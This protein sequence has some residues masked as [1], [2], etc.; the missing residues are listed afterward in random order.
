MM[1]KRVKKAMIMPVPFSQAKTGLALLVPTL[2]VLL[3]LAE[4]VV[5]R[6]GVPVILPCKS[7]ALGVGVGMGEGLPF[8]DGRTT[9]VIRLVL[10]VSAK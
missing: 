1:I 3:V 10:K 8:V 6:K 9:I 5:I 4:T 7:I 2:V